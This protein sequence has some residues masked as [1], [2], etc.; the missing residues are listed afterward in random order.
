MLIANTNHLVAEHIE[1]RFIY[2][3]T[4]YNFSNFCLRNNRKKK[5]EL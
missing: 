3:L 4:W 5:V 2:H 1:K